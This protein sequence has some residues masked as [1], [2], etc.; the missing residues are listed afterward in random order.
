MKKLNNLLIAFTIVGAMFGCR[1]AK[2]VLSNLHHKP[3]KYETLS[4][5]KNV[6]DVKVGLMP[7]VAAAQAEEQPRLPW[8]LRDSIPHLLIKSISNKVKNPEEIFT[9]MSK[10][11][12]TAEKKAN[13]SLPTN[14]TEYKVRLNFSNVKRYFIDK[15]FMHPNTRMEF[16]NTTLSIPENSPF[17]FYSIDRLENEFEE[18]DL[19]NLER[20]KSVT[21][22]AKLTG[23]AEMGSS[24]EGTNTHNAS[25]TNNV[26]NN[27]ERPVYDEKGNVVG[28]V[29]NAGELVRV[30]TN[31]NTSTAKTGAKATANAEVGYLNSESI[32]EAIAIKLKR[33]KTGF[34]FANDEIVIAQGGRPNGDISHNVYVTATIKFKNDKLSAT[35][36]KN[37]YNF[38][39][40][41]DEHNQPNTADQLLFTKRTVKYVKCG[42]GVPI[43]L[44]INYEGAIRA[45]G[46][47]AMQTGENALEN[48]DQVTYFQIPKQAGKSLVIDPGVYCKEVYK[49]KAFGKN[50]KSYDLRISWTV[51]EELDLFSDDQPEQFMQW[52]LKQVAN[53]DIKKLNTNKFE[54]Y[55]EG[56]GGEKIY[57]VKDNMKAEDIKAIKT[58]NN[59]TTEARAK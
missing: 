41:F 29:N 4:T 6:V 10:P 30:N 5:D 7:I 28:K 24:A 49:I 19:G 58:L 31:N 25:N 44:N 20:N 17:S 26:K 11:L 33:M 54:L 8:D 46:N 27:E 59:Y 48:D 18:I 1:G 21:F 36:A 13:K 51:E 15:D 16:L 32:K 35:S 2:P 34:S 38:S 45:V 50:G 37:V 43:A 57:I 55:F 14:Y 53:P 56:A 9:L 22:N 3:Y 39:N 47:S 12:P 23:G 40:L 42:E 52:L